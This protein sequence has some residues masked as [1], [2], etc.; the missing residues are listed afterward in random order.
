MSWKECWK[1][2]YGPFAGSVTKEGS[3]EYNATYSFDPD[4]TYK[5]NDRITVKSTV[6]VYKSNFDNYDTLYIYEITDEFL[7]HND[8]EGLCRNERYKEQI[9]YIFQD[10]H[11]PFEDEKRPFL[12]LTYDPD[13]NTVNF[14]SSFYRETITGYKLHHIGKYYLNDSIYNDVKEIV[15]YDSISNSI[16]Y[17]YFYNK[18]Y[19]F[20]SYVCKTDE[21]YYL[22][23]YIPANE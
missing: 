13:N 19:G 3:N 8:S 9:K 23:N 12:E 22:L 20:L 10:F 7:Y 14:W 6:V 16:V 18:K 11:K 15:S 1:T 5:L 17:K 2:V 21:K 4:G